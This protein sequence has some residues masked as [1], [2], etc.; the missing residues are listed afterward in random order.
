MEDVKRT[1]KSFKTVSAK[2]TAGE[3]ASESIATF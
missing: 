2:L 3:Y 1:I